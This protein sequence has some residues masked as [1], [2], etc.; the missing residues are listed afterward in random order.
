MWDPEPKRVLG[1]F[2]QHND[3]DDNNTST[4]NAIIP[5]NI[6]QRSKSGTCRA[7]D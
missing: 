7:S 6:N 4:S 3:V 2:V 1:N 5:S